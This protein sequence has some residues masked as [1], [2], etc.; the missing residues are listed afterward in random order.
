MKKKILIVISTLPRFASDPEPRFVLDLAQGLTHEFDVTILA[1]ADPVAA[2][3]EDIDQ[4]R[5]LRYRN[6]A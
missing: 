3:E 5:V 6:G 2:L 4:V 1:P